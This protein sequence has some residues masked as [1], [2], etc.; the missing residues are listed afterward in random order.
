M[1][2]SYL[3]HVAQVTLFLNFFV[4]RIHVKNA[5]PLEEH[6]NKEEVVEQEPELFMFRKVQSHP[7]NHN[8]KN[9]ILATCTIP[10]NYA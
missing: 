7:R 6:S 4:Y 10:S 9:I 1:I 5:K 2:L 3:F 8:L